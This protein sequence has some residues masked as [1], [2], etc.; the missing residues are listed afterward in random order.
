MDS[1]GIIEIVM[2]L[3]KSFGLKIARADINGPNFG[4]VEALSEFV[5]NRLGAVSSDG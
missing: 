4:S 5:T 3:E 2:F 1:F